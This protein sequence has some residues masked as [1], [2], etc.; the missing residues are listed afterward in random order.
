[1]SL[2]CE[3]RMYIEELKRVNELKS[4][5]KLVSRKSETDDGLSSCSN[6]P[7]RSTETELAANEPVLPEIEHLKGKISDKELDSLRAV[8]SR[9]A[10]VFSKHKAD[11]GCCNFVE[12]EIEIEEGL[13]P[14][15]EGARR[16]T[17]HKSEA[18]RNGV[19]HDR[20]VEVPVGLWRGHG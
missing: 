13:V 15:R 12:H 2:A 14:H 8:L 11:I 1:M 16:I 20:A 7:E 18:C 17:P 10:D 3:P 6:F 4:S 5:R 19:R 9:N